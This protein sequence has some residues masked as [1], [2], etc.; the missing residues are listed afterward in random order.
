[1]GFNL[2]GTDLL[3]RDSGDD[4]CEESSSG[5]HCELSAEDETSGGTDGEY[6]P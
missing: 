6:G 1:M 3:S 5:E 2:V 4:E